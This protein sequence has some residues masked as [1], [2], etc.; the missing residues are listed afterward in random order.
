MKHVLILLTTLMISFVFAHDHNMQTVNLRFA[1]QVGDEAA[2]CDQTYEGLGL[3]AS[4]IS[5]QDLRWYISNPR[6]VSHDGKEVAIELDQASP[7]QHENV[8][9]LDFENATGRCQEG[10]TPAMNDTVTGQIPA[11]DYLGLVFTLG[12]P[13]ELNHLDVSVAPAPL[14][15]PALWWNWQIGYKFARID[16][17]NEVAANGMAGDGHGGNA[18]AGFWPFHLG[19]IAC[20]SPERSTPP[21]SVCGYPNTVEVLLEGFDP[22]AHIIIADVLQLL[23]DVDV[24]QSLELA[25]PGCMSGNQDPDCAQIM[26]NVGAW[27]D[28]QQFFRFAPR[29]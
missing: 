27:S 22:E 14:N 16:M 23:E 29:D 12:I 8:A 15:I 13:F 5:F 6:L 7:W 26:L 19:S 17:I 4:T 3:M 1:A 21:E 18:Q 10:G 28:S 20:D 2:G 11:G 9:L 24:S 25:P